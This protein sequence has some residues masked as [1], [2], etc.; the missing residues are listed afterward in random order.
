[1]W[2]KISN[3][4]IFFRYDKIYLSIFGFLQ[5]LRLPVPNLQAYVLGHLQ[6]LALMFSFHVN[7]GLPLFFFLGLISMLCFSITLEMRNHYWFQ[8]QVQLAKN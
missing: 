1:F 5:L 6:C 3:I 4:S 7:F 8:E 2:H